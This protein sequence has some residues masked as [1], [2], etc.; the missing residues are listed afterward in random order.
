VVFLM[1]R[2]H[3]RSRWFL[4]YDVTSVKTALYW[5]RSVSLKSKEYF[6]MQFCWNWPTIYG[7]FI[8][9]NKA[10]S[11]TPG[12]LLKMT[13]GSYSV[14]L[15]KCHLLYRKQYLYYIG[16]RTTGNIKLLAVVG[17]NN[18]AVLLWGCYFCMHIYWYLLLL[19]VNLHKLRTWM[20]T[21]W[22]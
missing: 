5:N 16:V 12:R 13:D 7:I 3:G 2:L 1:L 11:L 17:V 18:A 14:H 8:T 6:P 20:M 4:E 19:A 15:V 22:Q 10:M 9:P 21:E